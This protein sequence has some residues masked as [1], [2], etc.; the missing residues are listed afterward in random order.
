MAKE[1]ERKFLVNDMTWRD[2]AIGTEYWQGYL[3]LGPP[4]AVRVRVSQDKAVLNI[5]RA[6]MNITRDEFEYAI[7]LQEGRDI[8]DHLCEGYLIHKTRYEVDFDGHVWEIDVFHGH[9]EGLVVAEL[10]L[11]AEDEPFARPPWLGEEVSHDRRYLNASL[12][13]YPYVEW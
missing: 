7:P 1:I 12:A 5:K 9:N 10:E 8:L 6:T 4:V 11:Q 13:R 3:C 2:G